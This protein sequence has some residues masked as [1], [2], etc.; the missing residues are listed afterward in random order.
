MTAGGVW[1]MYLTT[2]LMEHLNLYEQRHLESI[3]LALNTQGKS[4]DLC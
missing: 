2:K 1:P 3:G 4:T